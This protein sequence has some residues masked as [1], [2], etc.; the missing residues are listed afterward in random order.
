MIKNPSKVG[1]I[2]FLVP[3]FWLKKQ[4][5]KLSFIL[6]TAYLLHTAHCVLPLPPCL[7]QIFPHDRH[8]SSGAK[9]LTGN[10]DDGAKLITFVL[11]SV[12]QLQD[13]FH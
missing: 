7:A 13:P 5:N 12:D 3:C 9:C 11:I 8:S 10:P 1:K 6:A 2:L 4:F